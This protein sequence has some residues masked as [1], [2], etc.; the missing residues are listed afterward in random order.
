M[1][2]RALLEVATWMMRAART[3]ATVAAGATSG[4]G[5]AVGDLAAVGDAF[6]QPVRQFDGEGDAGLRAPH[7]GFAYVAY[8]HLETF[9][10][11]RCDFLQDRTDEH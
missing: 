5:P 9:L 7:L 3:D 8:R 11:S 2:T 6:E 4:R 10:W 1:T